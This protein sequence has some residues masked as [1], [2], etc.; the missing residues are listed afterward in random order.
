M[1]E[2]LTFKCCGELSKHDAQHDSV[3]EHIL[4]YTCIMYTLVNSFFVS[5]FSPIELQSVL[6][7]YYQRKVKH[8]L[9]TP[10]YKTQVQYD[11]TMRIDS[12][13]C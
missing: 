11:F 3:K 7:N 12:D 8:Y 4:F 1:S 10:T 5:T 2:V 6:L 9:L 13:Y